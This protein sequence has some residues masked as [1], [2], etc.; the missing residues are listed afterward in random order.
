MTLLSLC[1][2]HEDNCFNPFS[3]NPAWG[4]C[5]TDILQV[6]YLEFATALMLGQSFLWAS[7]GKDGAG[8]VTRG[9]PTCPI[10]NSSHAQTLLRDSRLAWLRLSRIALLSELLF[11]PHF[12][13]CFHKY[14]ICLQVWRFTCQRLSPSL[15]FTAICFQ[16]ISCTSTP[17]LTLASW[18]S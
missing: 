8:G 6:L 12:L 16:R 15:S 2:G 7:P 13:L 1:G 5:L 11:N 3:R 4:A 14:Q 17:T 9:S 10:Q 18:R